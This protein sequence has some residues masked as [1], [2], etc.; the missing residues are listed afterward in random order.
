VPHLDENSACKLSVIYCVLFKINCILIAIYTAV[1]M[2]TIKYI[3]I[4]SFYSEQA[5][6]EAV[7]Y[8][9]RLCVYVC[10]LFLLIVFVLR[11]IEFA[12]T[13]FFHDLRNDSGQCV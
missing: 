13:N 3:V 1:V 6:I 12:R 4:I 8:T 10:Q 11:E 9:C 5:R 2:M 7:Q